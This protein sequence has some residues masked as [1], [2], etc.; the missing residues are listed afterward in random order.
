MSGEDSQLTSDGVPSRSMQGIDD[1]LP[2]V[3]SSG[4]IATEKKEVWLNVSHVV[5]ASQ[6]I[7]TLL[8]VSKSFPLFAQL[9]Q[10]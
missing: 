3:R 5:L 7:N 6:V 1:G 4:S 2:P 10:K 8:T 9:L